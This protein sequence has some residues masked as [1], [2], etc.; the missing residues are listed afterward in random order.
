VVQTGSSPRESR[1]QNRPAVPSSPTTPCLGQLPRTP[2][3]HADDWEIP[4]AGSLTEKTQFQFRCNDN[5]SGSA[6]Q[7]GLSRQLVC[8]QQR[9]FEQSP[10]DVVPLGRTVSTSNTLARR[11]L[12]HFGKFTVTHFAG[13]TRRRDTSLVNL[14]KSFCTSQA[15]EAWQ[16]DICGVLIATLEQLCDMEIEDPHPD[17]VNLQINISHALI[18]WLTPDGNSKF[19]DRLINNPNLHWMAKANV[20]LAQYWNCG[21]KENLRHLIEQTPEEKIVKLVNE[22]RSQQWLAGT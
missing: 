21:R 12:L 19:L 7:D 15:N 2:D 17:G 1:H 14:P 18:R 22:D 4:A 13:F 6:G 5:W 20:L 16:A 10:A 9:V 8:I 11:N 3:L